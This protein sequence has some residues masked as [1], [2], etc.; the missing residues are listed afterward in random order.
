MQRFRWCCLGAVLFATL[1]ARGAGAAPCLPGTLQ[2]YIALGAT[3]CTNA[4]VQVGAFSLAPG[5][6]FAV[7][8]PSAA[9]QVTP[10]GT[11]QAP[12]LLLTFASSAAAGQLL[13]SFFHVLVS[14]PA[15]FDAGVELAGATATGDGVVT[16]VLDVCP[17]ASFASD[18]PIGCPGAAGA[19][20][21]FLTADD[22]LASDHT[23]FA[24]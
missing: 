21:A 9:I 5:Q 11:P 7:P 20:I 19:A 10:S 13:E 17:G 14:A 2:D 3:G 23:G 18:A 12:T 16:A 15:L 6:S 1:L 22:S 4:G 24:G 8:I